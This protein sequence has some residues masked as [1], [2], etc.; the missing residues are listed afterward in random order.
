MAPPGWVWLVCG[1]L[2]LG[3]RWFQSGREVLKVIAAYT[4]MLVLLSLSF[5]LLDGPPRSGWWA[6]PYNVFPLR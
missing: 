2:V 3:H 5:V 6:Y 1:R 4:T